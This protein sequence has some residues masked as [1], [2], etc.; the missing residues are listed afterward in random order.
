[1]ATPR[2]HL[3]PRAV[4][5]GRPPGRPRPG[6]VIG[7][8]AG[9]ACALIVLG[10]DLLQSFASAQHSAVPFLIALPLALLPVPLL[11]ALVLLLDRL[12]PEPRSNLVLCFAWGA[13]IAALL[14]A[15]IN[16][17]GLLFITQPE[18]GK[19]NGEFI[20]A[21][22]GAPLV[23]ETLK[24]MILFWLLW[25]RRQEFDGPTDGIMYAAVVGLGFAMMENIGYY[26]SALVR[27]QV[28]GAELL[29]FTFV[30][31]GLLS[32]FAH[33]AFTAMTGIGVAYAATHRRGGWAVGAG[34]LGAVTLHGLWNGL[35]KI[36][37]P[38]VAAAYLLVACVLI[39]LVAVVVADRR[40]TVRL[41]WRFLPAYQASGVVTEDD[42]RML[43]TLRGRRAARLR[44][45]R[46]GGAAV[47]RAVTDYQ[48]AAT[49]LALVHQ[50]A[51]RGVID[52]ARFDLRCRDL[53]A[54]M[55]MARVAYSRQ[56]ARPG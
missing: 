12:E 5:E 23:E 22:F 44:A 20:S 11:I 35:S 9:L 7:I 21:T 6:L 49:E 1:M 55:T 54:L 53:L 13:G 27:P 2:H 19:S 47:A 32:P 50:R 40:R 24:G 28:G 46:S 15:I 36:G 39:V 10:I 18:L 48:L 8:A 42:L 30:F 43:S 45:R 4:I 14:A 26:I 31:R 51:E 56:P 38:G 3:D 25:R 16:T 17:A 29:G 41:I 34:L 52:L 33:P 37:L